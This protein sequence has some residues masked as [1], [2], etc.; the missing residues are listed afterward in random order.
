[1]ESG[2]VTHRDVCLLSTVRRVAAMLDINPTSISDSDI[3]PRGWHFPLLAAE[4]RRCELRGDGFPGLGVPMPDLAFPRLLLAARTVEFGSDIAVGAGL[5]R[6]SLLERLEHRP[7]D[8]G[9]GAKVTIRHELRTQ[10]AVQPAVVETQTYLLVPAARYTTVGASPSFARDPVAIRTW[11]PDATTL[12]QFSALG[13][14]SHRIH[15]DREFARNQEGFPDLVV[16]GGLTTL[17]LTE[18]ARQ[19]LG[20]TIKR[21]ALRHVAPLF[22]DRELTLSAN[23]QD[24]RWELQVRNEAGTLA[25]DAVMEEA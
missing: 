19:D 5:D 17:L 24:G 4:T 23:R 3:L 8:R 21:I 12:F 10:D 7:D 1:M 13:F 9:G 25:V 16:N 2:G 6:I 22:A 11:T 14:N 20:V 15:L 18:F